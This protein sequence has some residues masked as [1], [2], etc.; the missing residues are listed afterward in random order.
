MSLDPAEKPAAS[1]EG[2]A[3]TK[4]SLKQSWPDGL[5]LNV[6]PRS[7]RET[8]IR[9]GAADSRPA[10]KK[11]VHKDALADHQD[12]FLMLDEPRVLSILNSAWYCPNC[13]TTPCLWRC[14]DRKT[15]KTGFAVVCPGC[16][17][18][19]PQEPVASAPEAVAAWRLAVTL[20]K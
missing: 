4:P 9:V 11:I 1:F 13:N 2:S 10:K 20:V 15:K 5:L 8:L 17:Y 19:I 12:E 6:V 7:F 14:I 18:Q 16:S 3:S